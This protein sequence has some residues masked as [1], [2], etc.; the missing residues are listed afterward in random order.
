[1]AFKPNTD[2]VRNAV[3]IKIIRK[4]LKEGAFIIVYDPAAMPI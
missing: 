3:S 2:D 1:L 4:L